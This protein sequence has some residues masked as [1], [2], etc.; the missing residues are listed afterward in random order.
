MYTIQEDDECSI[1]DGHPDLR[2]AKPPRTENAIAG[3]KRQAGPN[4][5]HTSAKR[6]GKKGGLSVHDVAQLIQA[7]KITSCLQLRKLVPLFVRHFSEHLK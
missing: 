5:N 4:A 3:K 7:K 2:Q 6:K 1:S